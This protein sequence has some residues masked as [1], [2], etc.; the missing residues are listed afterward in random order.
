MIASFTREELRLIIRILNKEE[1]ALAEIADKSTDFATRLV[2]V[3]ALRIKIHK[4][5]DARAFR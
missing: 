5:M 3:K 4:W 2:Q 1:S